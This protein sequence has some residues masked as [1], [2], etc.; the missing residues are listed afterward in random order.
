MQKPAFVEAGVG[1]RPRSRDREWLVQDL[2][3][4]SAGE[5]MVD[6]ASV[7]AHE[8]RLGHLAAFIGFKPKLTPG[9]HPEVKNYFVTASPPR[10][11]DACAD[12]LKLVE[13]G[14]RLVSR[15]PPL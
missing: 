12:V 6:E 14:G 5:V 7:P 13:G 8:A 15:I 4:L 2:Q 1:G 9:F 3:A 10:G 11:G